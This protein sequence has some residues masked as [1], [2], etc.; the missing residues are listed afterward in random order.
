MAASDMIEVAYSASFNKEIT[1]YDDKREKV[2]M[3]SRG[4]PV[5]CAAVCCQS[6]VR[7]MNHIV[8]SAAQA[9]KTWQG[10]Q[11]LVASW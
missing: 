6:F 8:L 10:K 2:I 5:L 7:S 11:S 1:L 3:D 4:A 9:F